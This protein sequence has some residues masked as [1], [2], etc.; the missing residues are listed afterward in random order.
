[1]AAAGRRVWVTYVVATAAVLAILAVLTG[2]VLKLE[3]DAE[4]ARARRAA[5]ERMKE[6]LWRLDAFVVPVIG[7]QAAFAYSHYVPAYVPTGLYTPKGEA[8]PPE[9]IFVEISPILTTTWPG[10]VKLHFSAPLAGGIASPEVPT[11]RHA[12]VRRARGMTSHDLA[13]KRRLLQ[14]LGTW[15][16]GGTRTTLAARSDGS[17]QMWARDLVAQRVV[18]P[19]RR[20]R[21]PV[22]PEAAAHSRRSRR[23]VRSRPAAED[24]GGGQQRARAAC[25][26]A[27]PRALLPPRQPPDA[28]PGTGGQ[29]EAERL[30]AQG[31]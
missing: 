3:R 18:L 20:P 8:K 26:A 23:S 7:R 10:W 17:Q 5:V 29:R 4:R 16:G 15:L 14:Q 30:P 31:K 21:A 11:G 2:I 24:H 27:S 9:Q 25:A 1:M 12:W 13:Q 6:A 19:A 22:R 28:G